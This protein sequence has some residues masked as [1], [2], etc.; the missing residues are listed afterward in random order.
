MKSV[1]YCTSLI[2]T[3]RAQYYFNIHLMLGLS[4]SPIQSY[5]MVSDSQILA[6]VTL[7]PQ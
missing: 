6:N 7:S 3:I 1:H 4:K 5:L 2:D